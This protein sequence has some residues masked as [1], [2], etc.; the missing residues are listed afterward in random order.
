LTIN[1][2]RHHWQFGRCGI[3]AN[4]LITRYAVV[5]IALYNY[6]FH[7]KW[8][9]WIT[10]SGSVYEL[11][12]RRLSLS[13]QCNASHWT[14]IKSLECMSVC[15]RVCLSEILFVHDSDRGFC[16]IFLNFGT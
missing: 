6:V 3:V 16:P 14:D 1:Q 13:F 5:S 8:R 15:V 4:S 2:I 7:A 10:S 9:I 11:T 12:K